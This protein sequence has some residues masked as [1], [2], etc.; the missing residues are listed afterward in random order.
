MA[1]SQARIHTS[2]WRNPDF[3]K[4]TAAAQA[5]YWMVLSQPDVNMAGVVAYM[6]ERWETFRADGDIHADLAELEHHGFLVVD[7]DSRE[8]W[9]RSFIKH[10]GVIAG[11]KTRSAMWS[12]WRGVFSPV[13]RARFVA[14]LDGVSVTVKDSTTD[15][16]RE[17]VENGWITAGDLAEA[18][19]NIPA[20]TPSQPGDNPASDPEPDASPDTPSPRAR[21]D[22]ASSSVSVSDSPSPPRTPDDVPPPPD[23]EATDAGGDPSGHDNPNPDA[24]YGQRT[25]GRLPD[26]VKRSIDRDSPAAVNALGRALAAAQ[27]A[28]ISPGHVYAALNERDLLAQ[29]GSPAAVAASRIQRLI[30]ANTPEAA[31]A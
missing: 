20:D 22:S 12:A 31:R 16:L 3:I 28:G 15:A 2:V 11:P 21:A 23:D 6:P 25:I 26:L 30:D 8:V 9:V 10:D 19:R 27:H 29:T 7:P 13:I 14:L 24:T 4:L 1:R 5:T 18:R 17:P